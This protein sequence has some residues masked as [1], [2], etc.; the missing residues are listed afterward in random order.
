M[1]IFGANQKHTH[2]EKTPRQI[3]VCAILKSA[4]QPPPQPVYIFCGCF[5]FVDGV[6]LACESVCVCM[7]YGANAR[8]GAHMRNK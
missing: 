7:V 3:V 5:Y 4:N 6:S 2:R 8:E 1:K